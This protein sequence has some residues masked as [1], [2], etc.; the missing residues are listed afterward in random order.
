[1]PE[2]VPPAIEWESTKPCVCAKVPAPTHTRTEYMLYCQPSTR[3]EGNNGNMARTHTSRLSLPS[4]SLS[5]M[6]IIVSWTP[7][8]RP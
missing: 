4:A 5:I 1:M 8:P 2:P 7:I 3:G 6:S